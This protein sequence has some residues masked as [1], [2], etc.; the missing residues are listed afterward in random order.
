[1]GCNGL[2]FLGKVRF[3]VDGRG[4]LGLDGLWGRDYGRGFYWGLEISIKEIM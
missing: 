3:G 4:Y 2:D 1:M